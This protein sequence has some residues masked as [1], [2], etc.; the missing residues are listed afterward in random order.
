[1]TLIGVLPSP[2]RAED[3][4][5]KAGVGIGVSVGNMVFL[6]AK[7]VST[8]MGL[9]FG[10]LSFLLTGGDTEVAQQMWRYSTAEPYLITPEVARQA[11]GSRPQL[12]ETE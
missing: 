3:T 6:P 12:S 1:M 11:I 5:E 10:G 9:F 7:A 8:S 4:I 2:S